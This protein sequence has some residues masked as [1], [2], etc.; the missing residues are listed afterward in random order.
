MI[1]KGPKNRNYCATVVEITTLVPLNGCDNVQGAIIMGNQVVV[2]KSCKI[3]DIGIFFPVETALSKEYLSMNNLYRKT[4]LNS[5]DTK[6]GYFEENGRIRCVKFRGNKSEGLFMPINSL[7]FFT[8]SYKDLEVGYEFDEIGGIEICHKYVIPVKSSSLGGSVKTKK[9]TESKIIDNQFRFHQDTEQ[10][11]KNL[12]KISPDHLISI[13]YKV[14]GTSGIS[15][16][17]LCKKPLKLYEKVLKKLGVNIVDTKYDYIYSSRKV[18][19]NPELN[20]NAQHYYND[21]IWGLAHKKLEPFLTEGL[22]LYYEVIGFL[23]SGGYIQKDYD[24]GCK[25]NEYKIMIYRI[26]YTSPTGKTFEFSAKQVQDWC[27]DRG[28]NPVYELFYGYA[29]DF[30][31]ERMTED[32]WKD[33]F[34]ENIKRLFTEKDCFMCNN[35]VPEEGCV[36]RVEQPN[37]EAYK[38]KSTRFL[39]KETK[40]LD[41]G[42]SNI[43]DN[44]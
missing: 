4:E 40:Q 20:P 2:D 36:I 27:K 33:L 19:K 6:R 28:L 13:T 22:T 32:N 39:E 9:V 7:K 31:D 18:I 5:D 23:P 34:L 17:V 10:L 12:D 1:N 24:Y 29:R 8:D 3:G 38:C 14:H 41:S 15:S 16:Y 42:E 37:F 25:E 21:D 26:T 11:Y 44:N 43:E 35:N 30:S